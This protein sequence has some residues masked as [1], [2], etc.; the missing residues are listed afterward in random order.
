MKIGLLGATSA[1]NVVRIPERVDTQSAAQTTQTTLSDDAAKI[2][3]ASSSTDNVAKKGSAE[4]VKEIRS[5]V[6]SGTY[7]VDSEKVAVKL[8]QELL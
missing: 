1:S 4:R 3:F 7:S 2:Y 5:Q 6:E 8:A